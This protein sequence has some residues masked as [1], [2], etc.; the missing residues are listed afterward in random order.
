MSALALLAPTLARFTRI[1]RSRWIIGA[2]FSLGVG[3][4]AVAR[5]QGVS[6]GADQVLLGAFGAL[7]LP[8]LAYSVVGAAVGR[9]SLAT[10]GTALVAFGASP[11]PV[12]AA[13]AAASVGAGALTG[14]VLAASIALLAHGPADP[15]VVR[16]AIVS[17]Y[18]GLL[19]GA[20]YCAWFVLGSS[21]GKRGGGRTVFLLADWLLDAAGGGASALGP[22]AHLRNLLGGTPP[23]GLSE[24]TSAVALIALA[25]ACAAVAVIRVRR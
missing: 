10:S 6:R 2:W 25:F 11:G 15:P 12:A 18:A 21:F 14:A 23:M 4:A 22:R 16:D 19:G 5:A 7:V 3:F 17:G 13:T 8:L 20:A 24:R 9:R 1:P